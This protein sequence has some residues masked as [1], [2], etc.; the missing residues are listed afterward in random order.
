MWCLAVDG[1]ISIRYCIGSNPDISGWALWHLEQEGGYNFDNC[2]PVEPAEYR[3][4][5]LWT[6]G[7]ECVECMSLCWVYVVEEW[8]VLGSADVHT[9]IL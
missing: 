7:W 9:S 6:V 1:W 3:G 4:R 2:L 8:L 5:K